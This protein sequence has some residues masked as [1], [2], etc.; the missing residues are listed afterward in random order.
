M[1][2][3]AAAQGAA[4]AALLAKRRYDFGSRRCSAGELY[5]HAL[6]PPARRRQAARLTRASIS[7]ATP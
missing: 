4:R 1:L 5:W 7:S 6:P 3:R 2:Q